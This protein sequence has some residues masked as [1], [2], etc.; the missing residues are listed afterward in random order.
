MNIIISFFYYFSL[1]ILFLFGL[2]FIELK[3]YLLE[4]FPIEG[5]FMPC[6]IVFRLDYLSFFF[7]FCVSL[8]S[9]VVFSY[10]KFYMGNSFYFLDLD[11]N[12]FLY[13]LFFFVSSIFF[14]VFSGS[15]FTLILGWDGLGLTSFL[16]V[17]YYNNFT[18]LRGGLLTFLVN[19][20]GDSFFIVS[21]ICIRRV[22]WYSFE[23]LI[24]GG[25][26]F[27]FLVVLGAFTKR[28]QFPFSAWLPAAMAAPTPVSSLV[29]SSTLVTAGVYVLIRLNWLVSKV[30]LF[31]IIVSLLTII[32][33]GFGACLELDFKKVVAIS[34]LSQLGFIIFSISI[35]CWFLALFHTIFHA[36]FKSCLFLSTGSLMHEIMGFQDSRF[37]GSLRLSYFSKL[38]FLTSCFSLIGFPF[39]LG[40]YSKD[41]ILGFFY[42]INFR[43]IGFM[44]FVGCCFTV[45]YR[46]RLII[47]RFSK[48]YSSHGRIVLKEEKFYIFSLIF[49]FFI[50]V[51]FGNFF[52]LCFFE[53]C[54]YSFLDCFLGIFVIILG[55]FLSCI[56]YKNYFL[57]WII[58]SISF[59]ASFFSYPIN[60][61]NK[62]F[63]FYIE[64]S[65]REMFNGRGLLRL[66]SYI[67]FLFLN[68]FSLHLFWVLFFTFFF[69]F[70]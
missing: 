16:L 41:S 65:W 69:L 17:I 68:F 66:I 26:F 45:S 27:C 11:S 56:L 38:F 50:C 53:V 3:R 36:F 25:I 1:I 62:T 52:Y 44:F 14:L 20:M 8:I 15:W 61:F 18:R 58:I 29:H 7:F 34:T 55:I 60:L 46:I 22:G 37:F 57:L 51:F 30:M 10:R 35:G 4:V 28:A 54:F 70:I 43:V 64:N 42:F 31:I 2:S 23:Y 39:F 47:L 21:F 9:M 48:K 5:V 63:F 6:S 33:G 59:L 19:R 40:F 24:S 49:I 67:S 12:R 32:V 13:L